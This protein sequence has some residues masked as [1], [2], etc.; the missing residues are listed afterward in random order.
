MD[1]SILR[2]RREIIPHVSIYSGAYYVNDTPVDL[3]LAGKL[4]V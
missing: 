3:A 4:D 2:E 1:N